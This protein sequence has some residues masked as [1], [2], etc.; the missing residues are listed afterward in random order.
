MRSSGPARWKGQR[1]EGLYRPTTTEVTLADYLRD[2]WLP[3]Y[4]T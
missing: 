4:G 1:D 2:T 3:S